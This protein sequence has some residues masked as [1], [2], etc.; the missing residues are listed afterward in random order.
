[1]KIIKSIVKYIGNRYTKVQLL[2]IAVILVFAFFISDSSIF[3][4]LSHDSKIRELNNQIEYYREKTEEDKKQLEQL[5]SNKDDIERFARENYL[6]KRP[7]EDIF[8]VE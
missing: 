1:M 6:M 3:D 7:N 4:R 2:A 8:I 5:N